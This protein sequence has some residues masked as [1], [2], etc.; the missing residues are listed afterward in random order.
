MGI[1]K[2][3]EGGV[4]VGKLC[5]EYGMSS[6]SFYK[7]RTKYGEMYASLTAQMKELDE[8]IKRMCAERSVRNDLLKEALEK[9]INHDKTP[10]TSD[11]TEQFTPN[12]WDGITQK[13]WKRYRTTQHD[14]SRR[15]TKGQM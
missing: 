9:R 1:L 5:R 3:A 14:G 7:W 6:A 2:H 13:A 15:T 12:G 8:E 11:T 4:P 10:M